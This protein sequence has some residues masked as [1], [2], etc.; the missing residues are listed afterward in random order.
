MCLN[1]SFVFVAL[2]VGIV[3]LHEFGFFTYEGFGCSSPRSGD[4]L[5][6]QG[7]YCSTNSIHSGSRVA[8]HCKL[9]Q[10]WWS[11]KCVPDDRKYQ[12][13]VAG[14]TKGAYDKMR[15][16]SEERCGRGNCIK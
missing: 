15:K 1:S 16:Q 4:S 14:Q 9:R 12:E 10:H 11:N 13:W 2:I 6:E 3:F 5:R 7:L 8:G